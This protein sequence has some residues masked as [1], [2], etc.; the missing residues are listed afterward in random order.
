MATTHNLEIDSFL[1]Q[2][3]RVRSEIQDKFFRIHQ[4]LQR[5][6][7][8][9]LAKLQELVDEHAGDS[10]TEQIKQLSDSKETLLTALKGNA[11]TV[12][13]NQAVSP[14]NA[15]IEELQIKLLKVNDAYKSVSFEWD[16]ELDVKLSLAGDVRTSDTEQGIKRDYKSIGEPIIAFGKINK[17]GAA[18]GEF[19]FPSDIAIDLNTKYLY[20][21][22]QGNNRIQVYNDSFEF[23]FLFNENLDGPLGICINLN[24]VYITLYRSSCLNVYSTEGKFI[25]SVGR[26]GRKEL[27]FDY[28]MGLDVSGEKARI[29]VAEKDNNRIQCLNLDL[30]FNSFI[31]NTFG[32]RDTQLTSEEIVVLCSHNPCVTLYNYAHQSIRQMINSGEGS[33]IRNPC[34]VFVDKSGDILICDNNCH[35]VFVFSHFGEFIHKIGKEGDDCGDFTE[36][37]G[38]TID[39]RGRI[40]VVSRNPKHV[41]QLF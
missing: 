25:E 15:C 35:S 26:E 7:A 20:I 33:L 2:V 16:N 32:A 29:Y 21:C 5:R 13:L 28:P 1:S 27:E 31:E 39:P 24:L 3:E 22:D 23:V 38:L 18:P 41:I 8:D 37:R 17:R 40:V 4:L 34:F 9:L 6:E 36:P 11:N 10:I 14:I 30:T 19:R 12:I